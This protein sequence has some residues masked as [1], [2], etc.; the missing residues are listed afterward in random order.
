MNLADFNTLAEAQAH[1]VTTGKLI[2]RDTMNSLLAS[3]GLYVAFKNMALDSN[4]PFQDLIAAFLDSEEYNFKRGAPTSTGERQIAALDT[5][6]AAGGDLGAAL[7]AL[8]PVILGIANPVSNPFASAT[9]H[10]FAKAKG[11][12]TYAQVIPQGGWL[13]VTTSA[14]CEAHRPQIYAEIQ[15]IK[16]RIAGFNEVSKSGDY[17]AQV[18][19]Q[20]TTLF[21][22]N[23]Y[24][25]VSQ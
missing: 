2:H 1:T 9:E 18:P 23:H 13:K 14:D 24:G 15:G 12:M 17:L 10:D 8:R 19:A 6:I 4:N 3:A 22:D 16:Q 11:L 5:M 25:V 7:A 20:Y 21:V